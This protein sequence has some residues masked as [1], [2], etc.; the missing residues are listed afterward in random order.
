MTSMAVKLYTILVAVLCAAAV[1]WTINQSAAA[2]AWRTEARAWQTAAK[3]TVAQ[4]RAITHR[5]R[6][7]ALQ[8]NHLIVKTRRS[9]HALVARMQT[10]QA[11][12]PAAT[13][14]ATVSAT[15]PVPTAAPAPAP[16]A[17]TTKTS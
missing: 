6:R 7:L 3:R 10:A 13:T 1:A 5:Y 15:A 4:E 11:A 9:Q 17:P 8:Y 16:S 2:S 14:S 12:V